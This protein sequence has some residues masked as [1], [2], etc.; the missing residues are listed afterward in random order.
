MPLIKQIQARP[1]HNWNKSGR[2][3]RSEEGRSA[4]GNLAY[5]RMLASNTI[6]MLLTGEYFVHVYKKQLK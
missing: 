5:F 2:S 1:C 6:N 3:S 4:Y